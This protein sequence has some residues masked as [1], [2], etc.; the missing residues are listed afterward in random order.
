MRYRSMTSLLLVITTLSFGVVAFAQKASNWGGQ[1]DGP[2]PKLPPPDPN[3]SFNPRDFSGV[4]ET[5]HQSTNGYRGMTDEAGIPPRTPWAEQVF[6]SR[7]TGR[8]TKEKPGLPPALGNDP[9]MSCNP[10]GIPRLLFYTNPLE[11]FHTPDRILMLF[12]WQR[13]TREIWMDGRQLP[14]D[15]DPRWMGYSVGR[16]EGDTL[17]V[18]TSGF[19]DRAWLD[20]YGN[21]Y[22]ADMRFQERW[23]RTGRDTL[24]V[25]YRLEDPKSYT[26]PW[27]ST[28]KAFRRSAHELR[29]E[30]C[31][32]M[33]EG[34]FNENIRDPAAGIRK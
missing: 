8:P 17:V 12:E 15:P 29:E 2:V 16:W 30:L 13:A 21:V 7:I 3:V 9:I 5:N 33:D 26:R 24:E 34:Y 20:Q 18:D 6:R 32:P 31:A 4:W 19:D 10:Y 28:T 23:K 11:F 27:V 1:A 22:S 14:V 25:V